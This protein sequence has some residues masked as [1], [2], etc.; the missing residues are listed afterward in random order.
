MKQSKSATRI[1]IEFGCPAPGTIIRSG[2]KHI[3]RVLSVDQP[4][5]DGLMLG[6]AGKFFKEAERP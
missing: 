2:R 4:A 6:P 3:G 5:A 1:Q